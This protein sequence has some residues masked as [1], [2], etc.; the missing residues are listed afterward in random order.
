M[1]ATSGKRRRRREEPAKIRQQQ[2]KPITWLLGPP[3]VT[4]W[5]M[6]SPADAN[7]NA[8]EEF[9]IGSKCTPAHRPEFPIGSRE[10]LLG[11][12]PAAKQNW[13]VCKCPLAIG[14][15]CKPTATTFKRCLLLC[16]G[17]AMARP[18]SQQPPLLNGGCYCVVIRNGDHHQ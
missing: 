18:A 10:P 13:Y 4:N 2:A 5:A 14:S 17:Q 7:R 16:N 8:D 1:G 12:F 6:I 3:V 9:P 15:S 11:R